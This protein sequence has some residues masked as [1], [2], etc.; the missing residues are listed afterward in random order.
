MSSD[1]QAFS[2]RR[3]G[4]AM[5]DWIR[6]R[7]WAIAVCVAMT[8]WTIALSVL[9][10]DTYATF[11]QGRYDLGNM[12]QAVWSTTQGRP[13]EWTDGASGEQAIRLGTHV[14][15]FLVLLAP[16][17]E[18][19]QSPLA[20]AYAQVVVVSTGALPVFWLARRRL[21]SERAAGLLSLG[22]LAYPW[23]VASAAS[24]IHPVTF[25]IPL[26]LFCVWFLETDRVVLFG[27]CAVLAM[28]T[29]ELM[30]LPIAGLGFWYAFARGRRGAGLTISVLGALW[31]AIAVFVVVPATRGTSSVYYGFYA[32]VGGSPSGVVRTLF[33]DPGALI[34]ALVSV[35]DLAYVLWLGV[36]L[37]GLFVLSPGL[38][39][40]AV[41]QLLANGL[42]DFP[43]MTDPRYHTVA[44]VIPFLIAAT[45]LGIARLAPER[46]A[47]TAASVLVTSTIIA[48]AV[49]PWSLL[50]GVVPLGGRPSLAAAH[51]EALQDALA[52]VPQDARLTVSNRVGAHVS[53]R[54]TL[55][56]VPIVRDAEW[57]VL[58]LDDPWATQ[59]DSPLLHKR[60]GVVHSLAR[61]LDRD[62]SWV[63]VFQRD[64]VVVFRRGG[65]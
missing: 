14:D 30:G 37:L 60:P 13:L 29:G 56:V 1:A 40:V 27:A 42:S 34:G 22:Y 51:V 65:A 5:L 16:L 54:R 26:L 19:W 52:L 10:R 23:V 55:Y 64:R 6:E 31:T 62:G 53:D 61:R 9:V 25:A 41:P 50:V 4:M 3:P 49:S 39:A 21:D 58:D 20:L 59:P 45:V 57:A 38:A 7:A 36:P 28:S 44:A 18:A 35:P 48:L 8:L 63:R 24:S 43:S 11:R 33:S 46:R 15:P 12:V 47:L 17:W 32:D 2:A